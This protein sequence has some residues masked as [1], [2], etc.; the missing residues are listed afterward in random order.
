MLSRTATRLLPSSTGPA[1][2]QSPPPLPL[3]VLTCQATLLGSIG[4]T[5]VFAAIA[6]SRRASRSKRNRCT[7]LI[8][9]RTRPGAYT[10]LHCRDF[11]RLLRPMRPCTRPKGGCQRHGCSPEQGASG[12]PGRA[13]DARRARPRSGES[14]LP[15]LPDLSYHAR[16]PT[17]RRTAWSSWAS[18]FSIQCCRR[19]AA[20]RC[21][22][23]SPH[24]GEVD[25]V[26]HRC[27]RWCARRR[28]GPPIDH[29]F[30]ERVEKR[31]SWA[32]STNSAPSAVR[33]RWMP[34]SPH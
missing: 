17:R 6:H 12:S 34:G 1:S 23:G 29:Q 26:R 4:S 22:A 33:L 15:G 21:D 28:H 8:R 10:V 7:A 20:M 5:Q 11:S 19:S 25:L 9:C 18:R 14:T 32:R 31:P 30:H 2:T 27:S 13:R 24:I 16:R 3:R